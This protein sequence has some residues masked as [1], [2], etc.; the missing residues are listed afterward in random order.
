[1]EQKRSKKV[2]ILQIVTIVI[3]LLA[4]LSSFMYFAVS[5]SIKRA[6]ANQ[7]IPT[8][9]GKLYMPVETDNIEQIAVKGDLI[10]AQKAT[11]DDLE[12]GHAVL[13]Q[14]VNSE[15]DNVVYSSFSIGL[16]N[17]IEQQEGDTILNVQSASG[18]VAVPSAAV[19]GEATHTIASVGN[20]VGLIQTK[21]GLFYFVIIPAFLFV[22]LQLVIVL[23]KVLSRRFV[24]IE[25]DFDEYE[26]L[27]DDADS[28]E[29]LGK[30]EEETYQPL[31]E[32]PKKPAQTEIKS[33]TVST[34]SGEYELKT[35]L[36]KPFVTKEDPVMEVVLGQAG[37]VEPKSPAEEKQPISPQVQPPKPIMPPTPKMEPNV[38]RNPREDAFERKEQLEN[39]VP[40]MDPSKPIIQKPPKRQI[41]QDNDIEEYA[42][43]MMNERTM[44]FDMNA[45][46]ERILIEEAEKRKKDEQQFEE[47]QRILD[48]ILIQVKDHE[49]DF[50]FKDLPGS[51]IEIEKNGT[52]DGF[53]IDTPNYKAKIKVELDQ[54]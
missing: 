19:Y 44:E 37:F 20:L 22:V 36:I 42:K 9:F 31:F 52:G 26:F 43:K 33:E 18:I 25:E 14:D 28:Q 12:V 11:A 24:E 10:L 45:I 8:I 5:N 16:V 47:N 49:V 40:Y 15:K 30:L 54:K 34:I 6:N 27:D 2:A 51:E 4:V 38:P 21:I 29:D 3:L 7:E 13:Y 35:N 53:V 48:R 23:I 41:Q 32:K 46:R 17:S 50:N 1:M 39:T